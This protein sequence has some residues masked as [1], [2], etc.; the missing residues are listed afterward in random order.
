MHLL[1]YENKEK[2]AKQNAGENKSHVLLV[3]TQTVTTN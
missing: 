3:G 2:L 1:H